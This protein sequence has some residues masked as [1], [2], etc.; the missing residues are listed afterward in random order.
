MNTAIVL[1]L[2]Q[3]AK[4]NKRKLK[5]Q[6]VLLVPDWGFHMM[7]TNKLRAVIV[8]AIAALTVLLICIGSVLSHAVYLVDRAHLL[9]QQWIYFAYYWLSPQSHLTVLRML[10][11]S[12]QVKVKLS[13]TRYRAL[14]PELIPMYRQSARRWLFVSRLGGR[15]PLLFT[16]L[17]VTFPAEERHRPSTSTKLYCLVT[18]AHRYEQFAQGCYAV[19]PR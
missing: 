7:Y 18:E 12:I 8:P 15:L 3:P 2:L 1:Y 13:H 19:L 6:Y 14:G 17:S 9:K 16:G 5:L 4:Y 10:W 11:F